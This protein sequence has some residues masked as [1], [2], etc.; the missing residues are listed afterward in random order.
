MII[1]LLS[2]LLFIILLAIGLYFGFSYLNSDDYKNTLHRI[3]IEKN[4]VNK[5]ISNPTIT[6]DE[7][8]KMR[9]DNSQGHI[10]L[11]D[12]G[13]LNKVRDLYNAKSCGVH[14]GF[15]ES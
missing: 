4:L 3:V 2:G 14:W 10:D 8:I 7:L 15:W 12:T 5:T 13:L 11:F 6:C 9:I 1:Q